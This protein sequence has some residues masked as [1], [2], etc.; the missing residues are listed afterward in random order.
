MY[1][2]SFDIYGNNFTSKKY[3]QPMLEVFVLLGICSEAVG[4]A[5]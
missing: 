4:Q 3:L 2:K 5:Y 1:L